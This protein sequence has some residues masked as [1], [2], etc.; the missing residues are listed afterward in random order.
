MNKFNGKRTTCDAEY[1]LK[2]LKTDKSYIDPL[3]LSYDLECLSQSGG[4]PDPTKDP[5]I[6]IGCYSSKESKCFCL[7]DTPG[8]DS[9]QTERQMIKSFLAY[10]SELS[11]DFLTGYNINRFDNT[12]LETRC[13]ILNIHFK[14]SRLKS[15]I[16]KIKHITTQSNQKGT[17]EQYRLDLPG[18][19]V[20]DGYE[21]MRGQHNA[22]RSDSCKV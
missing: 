22:V 16:S 17:Q 10:V 6:T 2:S 20:I 13:K 3:V 18:I 12:Y 8:Y 7:H 5:I 11:P 4:F 9:F 14:W 1:F 15:H 21:V 19:V